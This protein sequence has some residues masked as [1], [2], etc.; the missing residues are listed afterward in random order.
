MT[1]P[2]DVPRP[3]PDPSGAD[4]TEQQGFTEDP[5]TMQS[6]EDLDEDRI[7]AD[8]LEEGMEPP[9]GWAAADRHGTTANEQRSGESLDQRLAQEQ[10]ADDDLG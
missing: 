3:S 2:R 4:V 9:E 1:D 10:P 5:A 6:S 7:G 8:P